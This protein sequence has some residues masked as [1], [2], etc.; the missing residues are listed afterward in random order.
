M[1][2][3][4][5]SN[6]VCVSGSPQKMALW[7]GCDTGQWAVPPAAAGS[8]AALAAELATRAAV[9]AAT[10]MAMLASAGARRLVGGAGGTAW[11]GLEQPG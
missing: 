6:P 4:E 2:A 5:Y 8:R 1:R 3:V 7:A 10:A 11:H 9:G